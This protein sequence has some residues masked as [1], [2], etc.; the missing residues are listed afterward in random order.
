MKCASIALTSLLASLC[1]LAPFAVS[2][3]SAKKRVLTA[4]DVSRS[5]DPITGVSSCIVAAVDK[6]AYGKSNPFTYSASGSLYPF[7]EQNSRF[8]LLV[9]VSSGGKIR[10]PV[11][12]VLWRVDDKPHRT[13]LATDNAAPDSA[14]FAFMP[15]ATGN[16]EVDAR[17]AQSMASAQKMIAAS[18]MPSTAASGSLAA[19]M[20]NEMLAGNALLFRRADAA[21][22]Y[23]LPS[24]ST[25]A[26]GQY[27]TWEGHRAIPF[28]ESFR[29]GLS[30]CG[31]AVE[32]VTASSR[33]GA[34]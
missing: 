8:G 21:P 26:V 16:K 2:P 30:Q 11:G 34:P 33:S 32:A 9:G 22:Q 27:T 13:L 20:L 7:V 18:L 29:A 12:N 31:I 14:G 5:V 25:Y 4:W 10:M 24:S 6:I 1:L 17:V 15:P 28:D 23:G 19:E 3:L